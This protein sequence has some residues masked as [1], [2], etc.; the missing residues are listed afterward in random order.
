ME[1]SVDQALDLLII[2]TARLPPPAG[3]HHAIMM[4]DV[5]GAALVIM[6][7]IG[8]RRVWAH[9]DADALRNDSTVIADAVLLMVC[10]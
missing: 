3:H 2:L 9:L 7:H 4:S 8:E 5:P 10:G 6:V 1:A